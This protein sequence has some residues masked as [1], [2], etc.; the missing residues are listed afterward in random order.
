MT[1][2]LSSFCAGAWH[3][4]GT[5]AEA[6]AV[7]DP[8]TGELLHHVTSA[9]IDFAAVADHARTVG[10]PALQELT[11]HQRG[12]ILKQLGAHLMERAKDYHETSFTTG[13]TKRDAFVD[14]EGGIGTL[15]AY[16]GIARRQMPNATVHLDGGV[17]RLSKG[18]SFVGRHILTSRRGLAL[19]INAFNFP[20]WGML[21]KFA[22]MFVAGVPAVVK[23]ATASAHLTRAVVVDMLDS[24][25]LPEGC[26]QLVCG[27]VTGLFDHLAEQDAI[28]F[29]G[30]ADTARRLGDLECVRERG[31]RFFAEA[32]SLN[33]SLLGSD[34]APGT[35]EFDLFVDGVVTE[36]TVKAGQKCTAIRR[37]LVPAAHAGAVA[38]ALSARLA[39]VS[40]GDPRERST[41]LG[42]VISAG[43]RGD[44]LDAVDS[45]VAAGASV[46]TGGR[47]AS[48]ALAERLGGGA[49]VAPT[50]LRAAD[51]W[52]DAVHDVEAFGPVTSL[53]TYS[54]TAE[55]VRL[56]ARGRGSLVGSVVTHDADFAADVVRQVAPWHGRILVLD[57]DDAAESTGHGSPLPPLV[58]G[59]PGRA[60]G[61]EELGGLRGVEHFMQRTAIQAS[62][63]MLTAIGGEWVPGAPRSTEGEHPFRKSLADLRVGD[64]LESEWRTVTLEDIEHFAEFTGDTFYAHTDEEAAAAN[65]FFP[66]R[67]AH[68]YLIVS[69]AAGLFVQPDPGPVLAN[70]GLE[71][72]RFVTPVSPGDKLRVTL[73][74]KRITPRETDEYGEVRWDAEVVNQDLEPVANYDVL[75]L[76][77]KE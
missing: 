30:S 54:T 22:P 76:V 21:E 46:V 75:T 43:Q 51:P 69:F 34:A 57:R 11:F 74:A 48:D 42:P 39:E 18:G 77:A 72:L 68:G 45:L 47:E 15:F 55:A 13:T 12:V 32:D 63:T 56:A 7:H 3:T 29:T 58:H 66:G 20:V 1:D 64:A 31:T 9:G 71:G 41:R 73:T 61:G 60:G 49:F 44:V 53:I 16:S 40:A 17:E 62:P 19:Q 28:A 26:L 65:P 10:G 5:G 38:E 4:P 8:T 33:F 25:I 59:G 35:E 37:A 23:P 2:I 14:I 52:A 50:V 36:M 6:R 70:Y 67:V 24:G 27:D